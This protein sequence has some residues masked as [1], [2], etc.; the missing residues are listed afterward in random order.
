MRAAA[1]ALY[2]SAH[3]R[4]DLMSIVGWDGGIVPLLGP[5]ILADLGRTLDRVARFPG[6]YPVVVADYR[7]A[8]LERSPYVLVYSY[9]DKPLTIIIVAFFRMDPDDAPAPSRKHG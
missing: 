7:L 2:L 4:D 3:S 5:A 1:S 6:V 9:D 8:R